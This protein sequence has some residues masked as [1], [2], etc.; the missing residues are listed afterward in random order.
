[1]EDGLSARVSAE[2]GSFG[3]ALYGGA[4]TY[5]NEKIALSGGLSHS[6]S[7]GYRDNSTYRRNNAFLNMKLFGLNNSLSLTL[8]ILD[9][10]AR[11]PSS[12][13]EEDY[14]NEPWKAGGSWGEIRGFEEYFRMLGGLSLE[15]RLGKK[16]SN[17]LVFFSTYSDPYESRPFNI[18]DD[19]STNLGFRELFQ[20][21]SPEWKFN[22]GIE[23]FHEWVNWKVY[24][25][26]KAIQGALLTH[27]DEIRKHMNAFA[28]VQW[29]PHERV[30]IDGGLNLNLLY[31]GLETGY[32][33]DST[34]QS[35]HYS[36]APVLS[37]RI[38]ISFL[39]RESH[40]LYAAAG[41]GFSAPSLEETLLPEGG[42]N[43]GL[44]P[45]TGWNFEVGERGIFLDGKIHYDATFYAILLDDLLVTERITEDV[46]TGANAGKALNMGIEFW[47]EYAVLQ[48]KESQALELK[49]TLSY[50]LSRNRFT[51]FV[52]EGVNYS[53]FELPG[54]PSQLLNG[55][56]TTGWR[57]LE[58]KL[59]Y[60]YSGRQ[61]MDDLNS[62]EY[63]GHQLLHL[64]ASWKFSIKG[65]PYSLSLQ[66][67]IRNI[68]NASYSSMILV[69][70][71]SFGGSDPRYY[72]PGNPR[73]FHLGISL[74]FR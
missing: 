29:R 37:P 8:S 33:S 66:G 53:G 28:M 47:G 16:T 44:R 51:D 58:I 36:Y 74:Q 27:Q 3:T 2:V 21:E 9:L 18:V 68:F 49:A 69:N 40:Y 25:T 48:P 30:L 4:V 70:A 13:N 63:T 54:I 1:L 59:H 17:K 19:R 31:Y 62:L 55:I 39:L 6:S 12:L 50:T 35:G 57:P 23:Y 60:Q 22:L 61:W 41:H 26:D 34:D 15:S 52:D 65:G 42:V 43:T 10:F 72:Y 7:E 64:Q 45:E 5:K 24:E 56:I 73:Q 11:I 67:G 71:P 32:R 14:L 20:Y 38:G 46:F